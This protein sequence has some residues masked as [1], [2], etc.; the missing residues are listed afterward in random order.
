MFFF[1]KFSFSSR[2]IRGRGKKRLYVTSSNNLRNGTL[3]LLVLWNILFDRETAIHVLVRF[4]I[5]KIA[6]N[7]TKKK[8]KAMNTCNSKYLWLF[9]NILMF[10]KYF[11]DFEISP[12]Y[13]DFVERLKLCETCGSRDIKIVWYF[14]HSK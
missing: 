8:K 13:L 14:V 12:N 1:F 10:S 6:R 4:W 11:G 2:R 3:L 5:K 7:N 9:L